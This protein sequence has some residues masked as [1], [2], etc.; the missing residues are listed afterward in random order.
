M[1]LTSRSPPLSDVLHDLQLG[2]AQ[3]RNDLEQ[4]L[5]TLLDCHLKLES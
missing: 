4:L 5:D 2:L 3:V 1:D